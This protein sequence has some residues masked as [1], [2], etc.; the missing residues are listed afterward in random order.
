MNVKIISKN[1]F[2]K[3]Y[4]NS[5]FDYTFRY[6]FSINFSNGIKIISRFRKRSLCP[7][8]KFQIKNNNSG[9]IGI[10]NPSKC[11]TVPRLSSISRTNYTLN[12][13]ACLAHSWQHS[14]LMSP[15]G[16][17]FQAFYSRHTFHASGPIVYPYIR[18]AI[19]PRGHCHDQRERRSSLPSFL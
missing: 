16:S 7:N 8:E 6:C 15:R 11:N 19:Y 13:V 5:K 10:M 4:K 18:G 14:S 12:D 9:K 17:N 1:F 3:F 2:S